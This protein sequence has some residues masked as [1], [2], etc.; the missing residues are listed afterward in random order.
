MDSPLGPTE[1]YRR[2][3]ERDAELAESII[4]TKK[5]AIGLIPRKREPSSHFF[6]LSGSAS[7]RKKFSSER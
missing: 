7:Q 1:D 4:N 6:F 2:I 3:L 5:D